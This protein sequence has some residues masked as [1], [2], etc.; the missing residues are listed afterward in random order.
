MFF[1][2]GAYL[3]QPKPVTSLRESWSSAGRWH[4]CQRFNQLSSSIRSFRKLTLRTGR[5]HECQRCNYQAKPVGRPS[6]KIVAGVFQRDFL[7][8]PASC[9][10]AALAF[11]TATPSLLGHRPTRHPI[12][13]TSVAIVWLGRRHTATALI[14]TALAVDSAAPLLLWH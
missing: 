9:W 8:A 1:V 2:C 3:H 12:C 10:W 4:E 6:S 5:W 11:I 13:E 14:R 7:S